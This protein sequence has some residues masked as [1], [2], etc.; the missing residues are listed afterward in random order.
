ME[1][2]TSPVSKS[3]P[4]PVLAAP[5]LA[6]RVTSIS[7]CQCHPALPSPASSQH[8]D[9][10]SAPALPVDAC[11][12]CRGIISF[13]RNPNSPLSAG[14]CRWSAQRGRQCPLWAWGRGDACWV[15]TAVISLIFNLKCRE[16][17]CR[18]MWDSHSHCRVSHLSCSQLLG[19]SHS[20]TER[21]VLSG[22]N[23]STQK[24]MNLGNL[25][26]SGSQWD[27]LFL[28]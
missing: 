1:N 19:C 3:C 6:Q 24:K 9:A 11:C 18:E 28:S 14:C 2:F 15:L 16:K 20:Q 23:N 17:T 5:S 10:Y 13:T 21:K 22:E 27:K 12:L 7:R 4:S 8:K 26:F 25:M